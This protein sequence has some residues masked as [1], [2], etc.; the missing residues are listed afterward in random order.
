MLENAISDSILLLTYVRFRFPRKRM[1][2]KLSAMDSNVKAYHF[3]IFA[4]RIDEIAGELLNTKQYG[5]VCV[6]VYLECIQ[7]LKHH[8]G[9]SEWKDE[10]DWVEEN[11]KHGDK[12]N[13]EIGQM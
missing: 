1:L 9:E 3:C 11:Y 2:S 8:I 7:R 4:Q 10:K 12:F 6:C 13:S 5:C